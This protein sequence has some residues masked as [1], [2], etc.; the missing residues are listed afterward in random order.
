VLYRRWQAVEA[1][2]Q[3]ANLRHGVIRA[4]LVGRYGEKLEVAFGTWESDPDY[5]ELEQV[6]NES[7]RLNE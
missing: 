4:V 1:A 6:G 3:L 7:D 2:C 5:R